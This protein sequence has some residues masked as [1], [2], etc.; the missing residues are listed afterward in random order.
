MQNGLLPLKSEI[1]EMVGGSQQMC[2]Q[3]FQP[4]R[5]LIDLPSDF[6]E[7]VEDALNLLGYTPFCKYIMQGIRATAR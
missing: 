6:L 1:L 4:L 5:K 2:S 7:I 3:L